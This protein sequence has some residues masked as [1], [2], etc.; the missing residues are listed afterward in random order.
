LPFASIVSS[1]L[2]GTSSC[3]LPKAPIN[4]GHASGETRA[5]TINASNNSKDAALAKISAD[6]AVQL[7]GIS[8][9]TQQATLTVTQEVY[10]RFLSEQQVAAELA[11]QAQHDAIN[12][13]FQV[14]QN[15]VNQ[16][17]QLVGSGKINKGGEGGANQVAVL[18]TLFGNPSAGVAAEQQ[19]ATAATANASIWNSFLTSIGAIGKTV[20]AKA[21]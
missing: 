9:G 18:T 17:F 1:T 7:A 10:D 2:R 8:A 21:V 16:T 6:N 12:A 14:Q 11:A 5:I 15:V 13:Q 4:T 3:V 19:Q 20:A